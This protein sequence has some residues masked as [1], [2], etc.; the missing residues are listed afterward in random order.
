MTQSRAN[1]FLRIAGAAITAAVALFCL[2]LLAIRFIIFPRIDSYR[3][4]IVARLS[5]E[6]DAGVAIAAIDTGWDGWNPKLSIRGLAIHDR[7][8]P[9]AAPVLQL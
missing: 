6:L 9:D 5:A 4:E 8:R 7:A 2:A 1:R 3:A